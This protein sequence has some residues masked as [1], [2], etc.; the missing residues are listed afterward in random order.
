METGFEG[1]MDG[2]IGVSPQI[3]LAIGIAS[4]NPVKAGFGFETG[5]YIKAQGKGYITDTIN[6]KKRDYDGNI[7]KYKCDCSYK[8]INET[9]KI[10]LSENIGTKALSS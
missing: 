6:T 8:Y 9:R 2:R 1:E 10:C 4:Y 3:H 7:A 5:L